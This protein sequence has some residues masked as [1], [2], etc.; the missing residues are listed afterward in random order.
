LYLI[1]MIEDATSELTARF[2]LHDST[3][4]NMR[5]LWQYI[6]Q[7]GRPVEVYTDKAGL[8]QLNRPLHYNKHLPPAPEQTQ[9]KRALEELGIGRIYLENPRSLPES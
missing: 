9:I 2:V 1:A 3:V 4:E 8:F 5:L 7:H 6:D